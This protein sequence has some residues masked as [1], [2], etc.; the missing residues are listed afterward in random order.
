MKKRLLGIP[1]RRF[2]LYCILIGIGVILSVI[3]II[4]G[5]KYNNSIINYFLGFSAS[6]IVTVLFAYL[7][8]YIGQKEL[9]DIEK[10]KRVIY[11]Q[12]ISMKIIELYHRIMF[13]NLNEGRIE[14]KEYKFDDFEEFYKLTFADYCRYLD[15][16][17]NGNRPLMEV[18]AAFGIKNSIQEWC[19]KEIVNNIELIISNKS[20]LKAESLF[21]DRELHMLERIKELSINL[22]L[23]YLDTLSSDKNTAKAFMDWPKESVNDIVKNNYNGQIKAFVHELKQMAYSFEEFQNVVNVKFKKPNFPDKNSK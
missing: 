19:L 8:D 2:I 21:N 7:I 14:D 20:V 4:L 11:I 22:Y 18:N 3:F 12:P 23:P 13:L 10:T 15:S 17:L 9:H 5:Y 6:M 16:L 1:Y